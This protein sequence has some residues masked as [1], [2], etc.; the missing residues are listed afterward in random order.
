VAARS[1]KELAMNFLKLALLQKWIKIGV[2][3]AILKIKG[4]KLQVSET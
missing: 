3:N 1:H 4:P 2:K